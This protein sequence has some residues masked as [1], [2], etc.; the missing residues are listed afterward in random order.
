[1]ANSLTS[2]SPYIWAREAQKSLYVGLKAMTIANTTLRDTVAGEGS[3]VYRQIVSYPAS[4]VYVP[5]TDVDT[6]A[7]SSSSESL[8][9]GTWLQST[10]K[11]DDTEKRQ[12]IIDLAVNQSKKMMEAHNN[13]IDQA[14][15]AE[16]SNAQWSMDD[17]NVGGSSGSNASLNTS[18]IP[19]AFIAADTK[20]DGVDAPRAGRTAV[21][22]G[23]F[24]GLLKLQQAGR[25]TV[26]GDGVNSRGVVTNLFGWDILQVNN[27]P[28]SAKLTV[29][30]IPTAADTV[31]IAGVV[32]TAA[33]NNAATTA[34]EF[35]IAGQVADS[36]IYLVAAINYNSSKTAAIASPTTAEAGTIAPAATSFIDVSA[37]NRFMLR[38]KRRITARYATTYLTISGYGDIVVAEG[39]SPVAN[40]WSAQKQLSLF[41]VKGC[42]DIIVQI[43]PQIE[44][45]RDPDQFADITKS[46]IGFGKKTYADGAREMVKFSIDA[47]S[48]DW[49]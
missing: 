9:I 29:S 15:F 35:S 44:V 36:I 40:V 48:A 13:S 30:T 39:L 4:S 5:G 27:L 14:V 26:F 18:N 6:T 10:A 46:L 37:E 24:V 31:T 20:L 23:H 45:L 43:P 8:S 22:G 19:Q 47:G 32:F 2:V 7:V 33:A 1:M 21:V 12:S 41:C 42:I 25:N 34:G 16:V 17:G 3:L 28:Y 38:D 11:I 49:T